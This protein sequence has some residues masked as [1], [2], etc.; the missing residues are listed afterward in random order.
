MAREYDIA[1]VGGGIVGL[2]IANLIAARTE[3]RRPRIAVIEAGEAKSFDPDK[4]G[5]R[6]SAISVRS[7]R[8][9]E[10]LDCWQH[11]ASVRA[12]PRYISMRPK[13][14]NRRSGTSSR[15]I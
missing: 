13:S 9:F 14:G 15:T 8:L 4:P 6:V 12:S 10:E 5:L 1:I 2:M 11:I 3:K 7:Q